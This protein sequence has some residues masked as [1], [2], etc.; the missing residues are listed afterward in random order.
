MDAIP[1]RHRGQV[2]GPRLS[3]AEARQLTDRA[4][5]QAAALWRTLLR[6]YEGDA[7]LALGYGSWAE[8][9]RAEFGR[10]K[11]H[12]Y[13]LLRAARTEAEVSLHVDTAGMTEAQARVLAPLHPPVREEVARRVAEDG[14]FG[15]VTAARVEQIRDEVLG[16]R[17]L[18]AGRLVWDERA[19]RRGASAV[20]GVS[21]LSRSFGNLDGLRELPP[22][23]AARVR[24]V[25]AA[26]LVEVDRAR[27]SAQDTVAALEDAA[28]VLDGRDDLP[29][30]PFPSRSWEGF[31]AGAGVPETRQM[32]V[33][34]VLDRIEAERG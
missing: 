30:P 18:V 17:R 33:A 9:F 19:L 23:D 10:G 32:T 26:A 27:R 5:D 6:L 34:D 16:L 21:A 1:E 3:E 15:N 13:R 31:D 24:A 22:E 7:H 12:A 11:A 20:A 14:G 29:G 2:L 4:R 8:Y 25:I 28:R